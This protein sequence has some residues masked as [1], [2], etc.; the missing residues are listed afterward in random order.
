MRA[1]APHIVCGP[2]R[3]PATVP[4]RPR[5]AGASLRVDPIDQL[6]RGAS[7]CE[8]RL[9]EELQRCDDLRTLVL[10]H[11]RQL[12]RAGK[13][14]VAGAASARPASGAGSIRRRDQGAQSAS[15]I[16]HHEKY[17]VVGTQT[18]HRDV[19]SNMQAAH[20]SPA[21]EAGDFT[22]HKHEIAPRGSRGRRIAG[23]SD[24]ITV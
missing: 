22:A 2:A 18:R 7:I 1:C 11:G 4:A 6:L 20:M 14:G 16:I 13:L 19:C 10:D 8:L 12:H 21:G 24:T 23:P 5:D 15:A 17:S 3:R 9:E